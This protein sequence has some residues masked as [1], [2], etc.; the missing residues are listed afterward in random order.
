MVNLAVLKIPCSNDIDTIGFIAFSI[1]YLVLYK[2]FRFNDEVNKLK[3]LSLGPNTEERQILEKLHLGK[4]TFL[5][6]I[7]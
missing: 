5:H 1:N 3:E 7:L 6:F 4:L 2:M